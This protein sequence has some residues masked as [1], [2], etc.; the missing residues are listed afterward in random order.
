MKVN[1]RGTVVEC[2]EKVCGKCEFKIEDSGF[3]GESS[4][5]MPWHCDQCSYIILK[6]DKRCDEC[7]ESPEVV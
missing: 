7:L 1:V 4:P 3:G 6:G 5:I 2:E